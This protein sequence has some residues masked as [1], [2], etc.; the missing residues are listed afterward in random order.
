MSSLS[1]FEKQR[2]ENIQRNKELLRLLNL[3]SAN[4]AIKK[5]LPAQKSHP[6]KKRKNTGPRVPLQSHE[7][8][9]RSTR[10]A[11]VKMENTEEYQKVKEEEEEE[12]E[13][14]REIERLKQTRLFGDFRLI[15]LVTNRNLG[16]LVF[17]NNVLKLPNDKKEEYL[18]TSL[19]SDNVDI[20]GDSKVLDILRNIGDKF[21]AGDFYDIIRKKSIG[22][23]DTSLQEK[24]KEFDKLKLYERYDP[25]DIKITPQ[26]ITAI[27]FH[28]SRT[29][30]IITAGDKTGGVGLWAV[31]A[32]GEEPSI[33]SLRPHGKSVSKIITSYS[34][35]TKYF[36]AAYD[37]SIR[38]IDLNKL[39]TT[40]V[41][42]LRDPDESDDVPLGVSDLNS[43]CEGNP[44]VLYMTTLTGLFYCH[45]TRVPSNKPS[46][47]RLHDKK[48]GSFAINPNCEHQIATASL[49]R[50][51]RLWDLRKTDK[52]FSRWSEYNKQTSPHL[53][54][55]YHSRLS[56]SSVDW[57]HLD[58]LVCNGYDD[59]IN[60][61][62]LDKQP[63]SIP[64][65]KWSPDYQPGT[66][67][68]N[69]EEIPEN[70]S[71]MTR[72][73]HNCQTGRWV[74]ILK[75]KW[76]DSPSDGFEK[77][78]IANMNRSLDVYDQKG[79]IIASLIDREKV[80]AVPAVCTFHPSL[81]WCVG[82]T[83]SGKLFL[84]E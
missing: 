53:Y 12:E 2:Q 40:E 27:N 4:D 43:C 13:K 48:I 64:V 50:S 19:E 71:P 41:T 45:D 23:S 20:G 80:G 8:S 75:S 72:I 42:Y 3:D 54:G 21:S 39:S 73:R 58:R 60:V 52:S 5:E 29:D 63:G 15:D 56:V 76:Q 38:E 22:K 49:D 10:L 61:F 78:I 67:K 11:G 9:R 26:R 66:K 59:T 47:L 6:R 25:Q 30:R 18:K 24:R 82:G 33:T 16:N 55:S 44:N 34:Q 1:D 79:Q 69:Y 68:K 17:E 32:S 70:I 65:Q 77:F 35:P 51:F 28:P 81:N 31:D 37:G 83:A 84:Y 36:S 74:S 7:P 46:L 14:R 62:E 57:N